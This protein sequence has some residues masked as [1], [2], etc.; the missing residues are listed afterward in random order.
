MTPIEKAHLKHKFMLLSRQLCLPLVPSK[1]TQ[2]DI[3]K[4]TEAAKDDED[5]DKLM[6]MLIGFNYDN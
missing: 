6:D 1:V 5:F 3:E 2:K 4:L